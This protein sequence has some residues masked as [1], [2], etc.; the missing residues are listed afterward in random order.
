M[1]AFFAGWEVKFLKCASVRAFRL[2]FMDFLKE[3]LAAL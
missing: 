3:V 2:R 1:L